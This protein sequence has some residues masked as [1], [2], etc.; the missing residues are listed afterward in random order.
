MAV[1]NDA[2][3]K[4][5]PRPPRDAVTSARGQ[6][7]MGSAASIPRCFKPTAA[8]SADDS[9]EGTVGSA[10]RDDAVAGGRLAAPQRSGGRDEGLYVE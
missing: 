2:V 10:P 8:L 9:G 6:G 7:K 5:A 1:L 4:G 3:L